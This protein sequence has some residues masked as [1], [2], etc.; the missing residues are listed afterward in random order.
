MLECSLDYVFDQRA[1]CLFLIKFFSPV[2]MT[3]A[4]KQENNV[5]SK[6]RRWRLWEKSMIESIQSPNPRTH[7]ERCSTTPLQN[8]SLCSSGF[9][10][11][12]YNETRRS[13]PVQISAKKKPLQG[14]PVEILTCTLVS[15]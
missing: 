11:K 12:E 2:M 13:S 4:A 9:D 8:I 1:L 7:C 10:L 14:A 15:V 3:S 5:M 6:L